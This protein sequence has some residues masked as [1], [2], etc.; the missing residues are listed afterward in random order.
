MMQTRLTLR[1]FLRHARL[2]GINLLGLAVALAGAILIGLY[3]LTELS[4]DSWL[5][6]ARDLRVTAMTIDLP[7]RAPMRF[8]G[9]PAPLKSWLDDNEPDVV[10]SA[11]LLRQNLV[12]ETPDRGVRRQVRAGLVDPEFFDLLRLPVLA[13]D[14]RAAVA[15]ARSLVVTRSFARLLFGDGEAVGRSVTVT[16]AGRAHTYRIGAVIADLPSNTHLGEQVFARLNEA[17]LLATMPGTITSWGNPGAALYLRLASGVDPAKLAARLKQV[18]EERVKAQVGRDIGARFALTLLP[19]PAV[20]FAAARYPGL[21][22]RPAGDR[23]LLAALALIAAAVLVLATVNY[24]N[25]ANAMAFSRIG[26]IA[27]RRMFGAA[28]AQLLGSSVAEGL[29]VAVLAGGLAAVIV[30][31]VLPLVSDLVGIDLARAAGWGVRAGLLMIGLPLVTVAIAGLFPAAAVMRMRPGLL[32][33]G[34]ASWRWGGG[35]RLRAGFVVIQ[36]AA[37]VA[38]FAM[39]VVVADQARYLREDN[40]GYEPEGLIVIWGLG[41]PAAASGRE[42][43]LKGLRMLPG[44]VAAGPSWSAPTFSSGEKSEIVRRVGGGDAPEVTVQYVEA[45]F[46][47]FDALGV[48][49]LAGRLF[50]PAIAADEVRRGAA[51]DLPLNILIN[52]A[53][54][55][56]LGFSDP[57]RAVGIVL[58][59]QVQGLGRPDG[60]RGPGRPLKVVGVVPNLRFGPDLKAPVRPTVYLNDPEGLVVAT[61]RYRGVAP[62]EM[63]ARIEKLRGQVLPGVPLA[64]DHV[65]LRLKALTAGEEGE[66]QIL[67]G[68]ALLAVTIAAVGIYGLAAEAARRGLHDLALRRLFGATGARLLVRLLARQLLLVAAG[69]VLGAAAAAA[70]NIRWLAQYAERIAHTPVPYLLAAMF[71]GVVAVLAAAPEALRAARVHPARLLRVE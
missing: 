19:L 40:L 16:I 21:S 31:S 49:P 54:A 27:L 17:D 56:A 70:F 43:F 41:N 32:L 29:I 7:G 11:R 46:G 39:T 58:Q 62:G 63:I 37:A 50:D 1:V 48:A 71:A 15:D 57:A 68:F 2:V 38:L 35:V 67:G 55:R 52:R 4:F 30:A 25:L 18:I 51:A 20:H 69:A 13:G 22:S 12:V 59:G 6:G 10:A 9:A 26:E 47:F 23:A 44:V 60:G 36:V 28:S 3:V 65:A 14:P 61:L 34:A 5:P 45:G 24:V 42:A 8:G 66:A 64:A 53:A 33:R